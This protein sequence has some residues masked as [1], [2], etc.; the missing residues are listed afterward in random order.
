MKEKILEAIKKVR[1]SAEKRNFKQSFDLCLNF[2]LLDTKKAEN[3]IKRE[4]PLPHSTGKD[5]FIGI[6][7]EAL[8]PK[9]NELN[10]KNV[11]LIRREEIE[12]LSRKK[13]EMK[14]LAAKCKVFLAE[15]AL[16]PSVGKFLGPF[17]APRGKMPKPIPP[18]LAS[19]KPIIESNRR[20]ARLAV[21]DSPVAHCTV[22]VE[23]MDDSKIAENIE[24]VINTMVAALPK[25]K[26]NFRD[27]YLKM[28]MSKGV[29]IKVF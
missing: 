5:A 26:E 27:A 15:P 4:I 3:K 6:M 8:I 1:G 28:T 7:A 10:D 11:I 24:V 9:V 29:K 17:L 16:M 18:T 20:M 14:K 12:Q 21:K 13:R 19:L 2:K 23:D 25:G 22:G